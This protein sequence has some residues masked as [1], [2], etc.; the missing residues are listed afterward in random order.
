M[1]DFEAKR[2]GLRADRI[3]LPQNQV[4]PEGKFNG[5]SSYSGDYIPGKYDRPAQFKP[6]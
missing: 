3:P 2:N 4:F 6:K 1:G 5:N